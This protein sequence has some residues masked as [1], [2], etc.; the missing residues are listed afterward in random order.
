MV[1]LYIIRHG[2]AKNLEKAV[3]D[4]ARPLTKKGREKIKEIAKGLKEW[5]IRFHIVFSS[6]LLRSKESAEIINTFCSDSN[7][8]MITDSLLP[9]S[10]FIDLLKLLDGQDGLTKI[11][12]VGHEPFLSRFASYCLSKSKHSFINIKKGGAL[13]LE[14]DGPIKPGHCKLS[15]LMEP[16]QLVLL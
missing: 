14:A 3:G 10:K 16:R 11:A 15:W 12:I 2:E 4:E 8:I 9:E 7:E 6:P 1:Q 13:I 5:N